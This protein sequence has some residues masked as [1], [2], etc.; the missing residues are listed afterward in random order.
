MAKYAR[1][2]HKNIRTNSILGFFKKLKET[3]KWN[4]D[5]PKIYKERTADYLH[6][7]RYGTDV[8]GDTTM[9]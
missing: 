5:F 9:V 1:H 3:K 8:C 6:N 4:E 7:Q 2:Q